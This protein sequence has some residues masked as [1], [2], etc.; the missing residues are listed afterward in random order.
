MRTPDRLTVTE[1][2]RQP[3]L[4][5]NVVPVIY[6]TPIYV[7]LVSIHLCGLDFFLLS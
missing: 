2:D 6:V 5:I 7:T 4:V 3:A 1:K